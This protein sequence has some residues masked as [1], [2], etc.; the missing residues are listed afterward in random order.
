M[1]TASTFQCTQQGVRHNVPRWGPQEGALSRARGRWEGGLRNNY[2]PA[3]VMPLGPACRACQ[4][5]TLSCVTDTIFVA[6][7]SLR[8]QIDEKPECFNG[9]EMQMTYG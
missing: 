5:E 4:Q 8:F 9:S 3:R 7:S 2:R 6:T 1:K